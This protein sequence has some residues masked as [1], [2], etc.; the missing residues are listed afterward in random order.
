[1]DNV[2]MSVFTTDA[3]LAFSL[4]QLDLLFCLLNFLATDKVGFSF[5]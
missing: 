1:M 5:N 3:K 4:T 2:Y